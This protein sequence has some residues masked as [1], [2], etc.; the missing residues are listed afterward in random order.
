MHG[1]WPQA[2]SYPAPEVLGYILRRLRRK[3][4]LQHLCMDLF[5]CED[6]Q[7]YVCSKQIR[8]NFSLF[9]R[10]CPFR[11]CPICISRM[12]YCARASDATLQ[13][14][15]IKNLT[16][17]AGTARPS[18]NSASFHSVCHQYLQSKPNAFLNVTTHWSND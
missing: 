8:L 5:Q 18:M 7:L 16:F 12:S 4:V 17:V 9:F 15:L 13:V 6:V 2:K 1:I 10:H 14:I 3:Y 11:H